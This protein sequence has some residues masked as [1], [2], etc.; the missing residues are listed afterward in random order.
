MRAKDLRYPYSWEE[1]R[2]ALH[3]RVFF[4][5][6]HYQKHDGTLLPPFEEGRAVFIE[7]CS[8]NGAWVLEKA[9]EKNA[10]WLAVEKKFDRVSKVW[11]K[12]Q[13]LNLDNLIIVCGEALTF[14]QNYLPASS[15]DGIFINFPDPWPKA[16]H[17]KNRLIQPP[18]VAELA[19]ILKPGA[20][21]MLVTDDPPYAQQVIEKMQENRAFVAAFAP[22]HFVTDWKDYGTSYFDS[23]WRAKGKTIHYILFKKL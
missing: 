21:M 8:G 3:Q 2:P 10:F 23:L 20:A 16:K 13:N 14:S 6:P 5:P 19:R 7:Y 22:P 12:M 1:R 18:F 15:I 9:R 11:A 4:V 17:A